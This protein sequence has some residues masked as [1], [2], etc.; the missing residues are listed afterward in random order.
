VAQQLHVVHAAAHPC[1]LSAKDNEA[2]ADHRMNAPAAKAS[3]ARSLL[4]GAL[5]D[6]DILVRR[7][8]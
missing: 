6:P 1:R 4:S 2:A 8:W 5:L 3:S 7:R